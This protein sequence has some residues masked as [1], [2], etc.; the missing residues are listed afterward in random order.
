MPCGP[1]SRTRR[2]GNSVALPRSS[3]LFRVIHVGRS[4][5]QLSRP[6][7][8]STS[9]RMQ[10][11]DTDA[12]PLSLLQFID[13]GDR[14]ARPFPQLLLREPPP[15]PHLRKAIQQ[16]GYNVDRELWQTSAKCDPDECSAS[17]KDGDENKDSRIPR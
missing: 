6:D 14:E 15:P 10:G 11:R 13:H 3:A 9:K 7:V 8:Q 1:G 2:N 4:L 16:A 17:G 5:E 12:V